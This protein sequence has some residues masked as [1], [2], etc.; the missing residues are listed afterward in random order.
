MRRLQVQCEAKQRDGKTSLTLTYAFNQ[1]LPFFWCWG[2]PPAF[3]PGGL[4]PVDFSGS[5]RDSVVRFSTAR[6]AKQ[7][8]KQID[9]CTDGHEVNQRLADQTV[10]Q[11]LSALNS[12][13]SLPPQTCRSR[14]LYHVSLAKELSCCDPSCAWP[15][16][17]VQIIIEVKPDPN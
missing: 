8:V 9:Q 1:A 4:Q 3:F 7:A 17:Y 6:F 16:G 15:T 11:G 14:E 2:A 12:G 10:K 5:N 13:A